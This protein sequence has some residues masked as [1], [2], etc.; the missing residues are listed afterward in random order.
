MKEKKMITADESGLRLL[1]DS[2]AEQSEGF[3]MDLKVLMECLTE[4]FR[5]WRGT[6]ASTYAATIMED[7]EQLEKI[8]AIFLELAA[9]YH[10]ALVEY[11]KNARM[12][13]EIVHALKI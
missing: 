3:R 2:V 8:S 12:T 7:I 1:T 4:L 5:S 13:T 9:N 10:F 6:T 11:E